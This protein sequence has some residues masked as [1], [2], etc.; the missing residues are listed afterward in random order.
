MVDPFDPRKIL[1]SVGGWGRSGT[2]TTTTMPTATKA[3]GDPVPGLPGW[4][5]GPGGIPMKQDTSTTYTTATDYDGSVTG[6][7]GAVYQKSS[8]GAISIISRPSAGGGT[9]GS[10]SLNPDSTSAWSIRTIGGRDYRVNELTGDVIPLDVPGGQSS[11]RDPSGYDPSTG[12]PYGV[13][14]VSTTVSPTGLVYQGVPVNPDGS[15]YAG[16]T[17]QVANY[18]GIKEG[19][20]GLWGLNTNTGTYEKIPGSEKLGKSTAATG[21]PSSISSLGSAHSYTPPRDYAAEASTQAAIQIGKLQA[22]AAAQ[23]QRDAGEHHG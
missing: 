23:S 15:P 21:G 7:P 1:N 5:Y 19:P 22:E 10:V 18:T 3:V 14:R 9:G 17:S 11:G 12:L 8:S 16:S 20:G 13:T 2:T 6:V 4:V